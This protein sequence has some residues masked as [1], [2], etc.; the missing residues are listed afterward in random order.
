MYF[1]FIIKIWLFI[2]YKEKWNLSRPFQSFKKCLAC[3]SFLTKVKR[4]K[5]IKW[6]FFE[7]KIG[8]YKIYIKLKQ[9]V[10]EITTEVIYKIIR[11]TQYIIITRG[12]YRLNITDKKKRM[13]VVQHHSG[14]RWR[15]S[16]MF[17]FICNNKNKNSWLVQENRKRAR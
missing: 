1:F 15:R 9:N 11:F 2:S 5:N 3:I 12:I 10:N 7:K 4:K 14:P 13:G 8:L 17:V 16:V 6:I